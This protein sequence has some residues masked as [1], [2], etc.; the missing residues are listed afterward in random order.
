ME[1]LKEKLMDRGIGLEETDP[2]TVD[3]KEALIFAYL[4]LRSLLGK[5]N[6]FKDNTGARMDSV[7]GSIHQPAIVDPSST[8]MYPNFRFLLRR[9]VS[10]P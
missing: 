8:G 9:R 4:G 6:V 5:P 2:E 10:S 1:N 7:A 3:Y